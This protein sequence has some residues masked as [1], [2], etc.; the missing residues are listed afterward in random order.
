MATPTVLIIE[1]DS[2]LLRGLVDNFRAQDYRVITAADGQKG[3][4]AALTASLSWSFSTSWPSEAERLRGVPVDPRAWSG[5][6]DYH[7]TAR[8]RERTLSRGLEL[9]A[10][11]T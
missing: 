1:D 10:T 5:R 3:L 8:G 2:T 11:T 9:G 4:D 7:V 6:A